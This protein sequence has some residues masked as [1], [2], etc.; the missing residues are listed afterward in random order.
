MFPAVSAHA[1]WTAQYEPGVPATASLPEG[2]FH[3]I[4]EAAAGGAP[5]F[6]ALE[7]YGRRLSYAEL[8]AAAGAVAGRLVQTPGFF[9]GARVLVDLPNGLPL[10]KAVLGAWKAGAIVVPSGGLLPEA[11]RRVAEGAC[12]LVTTADRADQWAPVLSTLRSPC[13]VADLCH[14]LP[15]VLRL[16]HRAS[17][18]RRAPTPLT[19]AVPWREWGLR[20]APSRLP[21][22]PVAADAAA[23]ALPGPDGADR[24]VFSHRQLVAGASVL[25]AWLTDVFL[26][27]ETWLVLAEVAS[28]L[29]L[30]A[31]LGTALG[32]RAQVVLLPR[33]TGQDALDA[34][35]YVRPSYALCD[36]ATVQSLVAT[37]ELSR[38]SLDHTRAILVGEPLHASVVRAFAESTG[39]DLCVGYAPEGMAG[40]ATCNLVNGRRIPGSIGL[41]LPGVSARTTGPDGWPTRDGE[42]GV[43]ELSGPHSAPGWLRTGLLARMD[44]Q[45]Y[46]HAT[47]LPGHSS[48]ARTPVAVGLMRE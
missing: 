21:D 22:E 1:P 12:T 47:G 40:L 34:L 41:P 9:R 4:V 2:P 39:V 45:G 28:P 29:G 43:L 10:V 13:V 27:D 31:V 23:L 3:H 26:G 42:T 6:P 48:P 11:R 16:I 8:D 24:A 14:D 32:M 35:R 19:G 17:R 36:A 20:Q 15:P 44:A 37:P 46:V 18:F 25:R 30:T 5:T 7:F 33:W 38:L